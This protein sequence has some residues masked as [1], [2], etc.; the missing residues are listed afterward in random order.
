MKKRLVLA[1]LLALGMAATPALAEPAAHHAQAQEHKQ[2]TIP[3]ANYDG[4]Q[5]W[6]VGNDHTLYIEDQSNHWYKADLMFPAFDLPYANVI[7]FDTGPIGNF[8]HFSSII[9]N[10]RRYQVR[11]LVKISGKP[12]RPDYARHHSNKS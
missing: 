12:P 4:I 5:N 8:D 6:Q 3:F 7:G 1:P 9:V 2:A 10:G 11:S